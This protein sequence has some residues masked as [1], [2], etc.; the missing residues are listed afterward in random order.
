MAGDFRAAIGEDVLSTCPG[1]SPSPTT[2]D[3]GTSDQV[4]GSVSCG[5]FNDHPEVMWT[6]DAQLLLGQAQGPDIPSVFAWWKRNG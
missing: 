5:T 1:F 3:Y 4:A 2:W 6:S